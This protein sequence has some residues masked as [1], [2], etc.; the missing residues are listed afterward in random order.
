MK[1]ITGL[2]SIILSLQL[3]TFARVF[4]NGEFIALTIPQPPASGT[5]KTF[6]IY[7]VFLPFA[8][9]IY[10]IIRGEIASYRSKCHK[11]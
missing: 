5:V 4:N 9:G 7:W 11:D 8:Y 2:I 1:Q 6:S 3:L 10:N